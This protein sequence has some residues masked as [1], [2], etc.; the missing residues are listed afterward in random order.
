MREGV[1]LNLLL[2]GYLK[3]SHLRVFD[4]VGV[5]VG[6]DLF[7]VG[8]AL[9]EV[10]MFDVILLAVVKVDRL[11]V[12]RAE[13]AGKINLADDARFASDVDNDEVVASDGTKADGVRGV[14]LLRPVI[15]IAGTMEIA[16]F[17]QLWQQFR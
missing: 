17:R 13:G 12:D 16:G 5:I 10:E 15:K 11:F 4:G 8:F 3:H 2:I 7:D 9:L 14:G 6:S 1:S